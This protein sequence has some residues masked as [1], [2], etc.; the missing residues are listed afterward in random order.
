[1][2]IPQPIHEI[3]RGSPPILARVAPCAVT[4]LEG[5][6]VEVEVDTKQGLPG[7]TIPDQKPYAFCILLSEE[8]FPLS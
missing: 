3:I 2:I 5:V 4:G 7:V 1:M 8:L 6:I